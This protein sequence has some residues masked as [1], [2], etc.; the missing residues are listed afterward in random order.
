MSK[1][2]C[3]GKRYCQFDCSSIRSLECKTPLKDK[4][5]WAKTF[6]EKLLTIQMNY[7][8]QK[9]KALKK[10][11]EN[12]NSLQDKIKKQQN[13]LD[14]GKRW[15][16]QREIVSSTFHIGSDSL[17]EQLE[18]R[19]YQFRL[20]VI[21]DSYAYEQN[22][23]QEIIQ[24]DHELK[25]KTELT[26]VERETERAE[27]NYQDIMKRLEFQKMQRDRLAR[28][29]YV[30][31]LARA[32]YAFEQK[33]VHA[34]QRLDNARATLNNQLIKN[35]DA[36]KKGQEEA[37]KK[38]QSDIDEIVRKENKRRENE[39]N[40]V[41][42]RYEERISKI[43]LEQAKKIVN[44][45]FALGIQN[46]KTPKQLDDLK[47]TQEGIMK[48]EY[49]IKKTAV[50]LLNQNRDSVIK[51]IKTQM[52]KQKANNLINKEFLG[53]S[54]QAIPPGF[55][56][57]KLKN[58]VLDLPFP[59]EVQVTD[60]LASPY[61]VTCVTDRSEKS[62][63][64]ELNNL[65]KNIEEGRFPFKDDAAIQLASIPEFRQFWI[66]TREFC[67][68]VVDGMVPKTR[69]LKSFFNNQWHDKTIPVL[70]QNVNKNEGVPRSA[71]V[72]LFFDQLASW[73]TANEER[74]KCEDIRKL[75]INGQAP[76]GKSFGKA[77]NNKF[78]SVLP[79]FEE[80]LQK[81]C[82]AKFPESCVV[83]K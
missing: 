20:Q 28:E 75:I 83:R 63:L 45:S 1:G 32:R 27:F 41:K 52:E 43:S 82:L 26:F 49:L 81:K 9:K 31:G 50:D 2:T 61:D 3:D 40:K 33:Y 34:K 51:N 80:D 6:Q 46:S 13:R 48:S 56:P 79:A 30:V 17:S 74:C 16:N 72:A 60:D 44:K 55:S 29:N 36:Y 4:A 15:K 25:L 35:D 76:N 42:K 14:S 73:A 37:Q 19:N 54:I 38:Y 68:T 64:I 77:F 57:P 21:E 71:T 39:I 12:M 62:Q 11:L 10:H 70:I 7:E 78:G 24:F 8:E 66:T 47:K 18:K 69:A 23:I 67:K 65:K 59:I 58:N 53:Q 22:R 5:E